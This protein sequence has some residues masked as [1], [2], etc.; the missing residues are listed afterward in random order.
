MRDIDRL[1][2]GEAGV[3]I[4]TRFAREATVDHR[5]DTRQGDAG[6]GHV[7]GQHDAPGAG[8]GGVQRQLLFGQRQLAV[9]QD[10]LHVIAIETL[11]EHGLCSCNLAPAW[12]ESKH[13][14]I[15]VFQGLPCHTRKLMLDALLRARWRVVDA[16]RITTTRTGDARCVEPLRD[17]LA[18]QGRRH[19]Q[20][21]QFGPQRGLHIQRERSAEIPGQMAFVEFVEQD[22]ADPAQFRIILDQPREDALGNHLDP[23]RRTDLR[24]EADAIAD[25]ATDLLTKLLRHELRRRARGDAPR[26]QHQDLL[27]SE[28]RRIEQRQRHLRRLAGTRGRLKH[29]P[30]G[31]GE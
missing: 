25:G 31:H 28:P 19:H 24:F 9:Q 30:R 8:L 23:R 6:L 2:S 27:P 21:P 13:V 1:Q 5:A 4:E 11:H 18:V 22:R 20:Q 29:Q 15:A 17:A 3:R 10:D 14:A 26:L 16:H 7:G 12:E